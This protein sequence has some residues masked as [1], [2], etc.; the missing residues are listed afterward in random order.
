MCPTTASS[1]QGPVLPGGYCAADP[2]V[3]LLR[4][5]AP[6]LGWKALAMAFLVGVRFAVDSYGEGRAVKFEH[7]AHFIN[8]QHTIPKCQKNKAI[9]EM[10]C[11]LVS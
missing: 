7:L 6:W 9:T 2:L 8:W 11:M 3:Y 4:K 1:C 10:T 5:T